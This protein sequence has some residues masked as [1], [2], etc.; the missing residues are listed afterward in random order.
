M[1]RKYR[2]HYEPQ[3]DRLSIAGKTNSDKVVGSVRLLNVILDFNMENK[4]VNAELL[5]ASQYL[6][7]IGIDSKIL[8]KAKEGD[9]VFKKFRNGYEIIFILKTNKE[10]VSI[11]YNIHLPQKQVIIAPTAY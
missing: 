3:F 10:S 2:I 5:K 6:E 7:S 8:N 4:V 9:L 11:P 1:E